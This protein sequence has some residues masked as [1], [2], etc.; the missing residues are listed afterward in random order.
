MVF[1]V[2]F[3]RYSKLFTDMSN[4]IKYHKNK[5]IALERDNK[6]LGD[7]FKSL[8]ESTDTLTKLNG[9][10]EDMFGTL[11]QLLGKLL[12]MS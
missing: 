9:R 10:Q 12:H 2:L 8:K 5:E 7:A 3:N 1:N 6:L 4:A 11:N